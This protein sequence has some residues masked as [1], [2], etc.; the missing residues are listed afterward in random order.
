MRKVLFTVA[1]LLTACFVSAQVS[2]VTVSYTHLDV[3]KRQP[4]SP[5][6]SPLDA[7]VVSFCVASTAL[8]TNSRRNISLSLYKNFL[9]MGKMFSVVTPIFPFCILFMVLSYYVIYTFELS[10]CWMMGDVYKRQIP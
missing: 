2:V 8:E 1:L 4:I 6:N 7:R 3:Y 5:L 9:M 10:F